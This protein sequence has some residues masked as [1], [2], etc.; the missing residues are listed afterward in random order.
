MI[1]GAEAIEQPY[2]GTYRERIYDIADP[3]NSGEWTWIKFTEE[4]EDWCGEFRGKYRGVA[5]SERLGIV[6]V[7]TSDHLYML[8][9]HHAN[10]IGSLRQP[11]Y[12]G[13]TTSPLGDILVTDWYSL[14]RFT[15]NTI[16]SREPI[17][18]PI[19]P[20]FLQ[21]HEWNRNVLRMT[22][23]EFLNWSHTVELFWDCASGQWVD[24]RSLDPLDR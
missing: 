4:D 3:W 2:A 20:D 12:V 18:T 16:E 13:I 22:C 1:M 24:G 10:L 21:F 23:E 11:A 5:R 15:S 9:I 8:D 17:D 14:E 6:V 19:S 7:L